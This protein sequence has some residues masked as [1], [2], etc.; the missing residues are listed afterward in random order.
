MNAN[1]CT[2]TNE[3]FAFNALDLT[4]AASR[5]CV[6]VLYARVSMESGFTR[7]CSSVLSESELKRAD[8]FASTDEKNRFIQ[9]R[10]FR[11]YCGARALGTIRPLSQINFSESE[12]GRPFLQEL[13]RTWFSFSSCRSDFIGA[14]SSTHAVGVDLED[15]SRNVETAE[16]AR[17][18]FSATEAKAVEEAT[19]KDRLQT[20]YQYWVLKESALKSIGEGLPFGLDV[21]KFEL[22]PELRVVHAAYEGGGA[23]LFDAHMIAGTSS[24]AALVT[25]CLT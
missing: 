17:K 4:P 14:W 11:R 25:R 23:K 22:E 24:C 7:L 13:P 9:R 21:F 16:L 20:F 10:A 6:Q 18:F 1:S 3:Y 2:K 8:R 19:S 15:P 5:A 12:K